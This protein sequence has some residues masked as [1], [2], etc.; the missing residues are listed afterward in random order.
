MTDTERLDWM[1]FYGAQVCTS[2]DGEDCWVKWYT[3]NDEP[4][5]A[6]TGIYDDARQAID[7]AMEMEQQGIVNER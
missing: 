2:K 1:I 4:G 3:D 6:K 7:R 5:D